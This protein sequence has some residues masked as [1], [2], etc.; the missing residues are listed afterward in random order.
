MH[1]WRE[2]ESKPV[3]VL[4]AHYHW[5]LADPLPPENPMLDPGVIRDARALTLL[6]E[7][8]PLPLAPPRRPRVLSL[9]R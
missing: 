5:L 1:S 8:A 6:R 3:P 9:G 7:R 4:H 2:L